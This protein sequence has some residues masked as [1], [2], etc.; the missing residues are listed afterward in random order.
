[1]KDVESGL[2]ELVGIL[3]SATAPQGDQGIQSQLLVV[4]DDGGDHVLFLT[5]NDHAIDLVTAGS[6]NGSADSQDA[7]Q[8][9]RTQGDGAVLR[10]SEEA[11]LN[12]NQLHVVLSD[13]CL[14]KSTDCGIE[15]RAVTTS[16]EDADLLLGHDDS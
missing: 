15:S 3:G 6:Q 5:S 12:T 7:G 1:M 4:V 11:V 10:Q 9:A 8:S 14:A 16:G 13:G 2:G